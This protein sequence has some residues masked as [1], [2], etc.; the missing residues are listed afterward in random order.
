MDRAGAGI[1]FREPSQLFMNQR[2]G[3]FRDVSEQAGEA[4]K[5][6]R[7]GRG[8][9]L[10]DLFNDGAQEVVA[11]DLDGQAVIL[12]PQGGPRNHWISFEFAGTLMH[13]ALA[14]LASNVSLDQGFNAALT[15]SAGTVRE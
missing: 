6:P 9:V 1:H 15:T 7:V 12:R 5:R 11:E 8:L 10:G 2:D 13:Q 4:M 3:T 14:N